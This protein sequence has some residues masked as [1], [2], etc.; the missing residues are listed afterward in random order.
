[1]KPKPA[2]R[3]NTGRKT[4]KV[5]QHFPPG[6]NQERVQAVIDYYENMT[7]EERAADIEAAREA[8][9]QTLISVPTALVPAIL[10]LIARHE[11]SA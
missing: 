8:A 2:A 9:G 6:W 3:R 4:G 10:K 11:K 1:M 5:K 7:D